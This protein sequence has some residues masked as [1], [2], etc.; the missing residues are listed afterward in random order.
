MI[1]R[2]W[3]FGPRSAER[4]EFSRSRDLPP[5]PFMCCTFIFFFTSFFGQ[6]FLRVGFLPLVEWFYGNIFLEVG[7]M[8][9]GDSSGDMLSSMN[10]TLLGIFSWPFIFPV[11]CWAVNWFLNSSKPSGFAL[12]LYLYLFIFANYRVCVYCKAIRKFQNLINRRKSVNNDLWTYVDSI[13]T[14]WIF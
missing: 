13:S 12:F 11:Q 14:A 9:S 5:T 8:P 6:I 10:M 7:R 3:R 2:I 1:R 4:T